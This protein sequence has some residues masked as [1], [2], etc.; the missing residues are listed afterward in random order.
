[1]R[2]VKQAYEHIIRNERELNA[3]RQYIRDNPARWAEDPENPNRIIG[4]R[5]CNE[6]STPGRQPMSGQTDRAAEPQ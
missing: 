2:S 3:V 1:M 6:A 5:H 4:L